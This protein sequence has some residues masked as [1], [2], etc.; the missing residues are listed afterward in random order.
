M[1]L[2][3]LIAAEAA[4][5]TEAFASGQKLHETD[6][7]ALALLRSAEERGAV[8]SPGALG[9][10]LRLTSGATTFLVNRLERAALVERTRDQVDQRKVWL[11]FTNGGRQLADRLVSPIDRLSA[12]VMDQFSQEELKVAQR[13][14]LATTDAMAAYRATLICQS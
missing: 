2:V 12:G 9:A 5:I 14:L 1:Q 8:L 10:Q 13:F 7:E 3:P 6:V 4:R 11:G